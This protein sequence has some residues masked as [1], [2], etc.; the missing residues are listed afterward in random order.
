MK[1]NNLFLKI[2]QFLLVGSFIFWLGSY[3]SRHLVVYQLFEPEGLVLRS[4]YDVENLKTVWITISPLIVSNIIAFPI[5][6]VLYAIYLIVSKDSLKKEGWLFISTLIILVTAPF[7]I[8][9]LLKDYKIISLIY[10]SVIDSN[11]VLELVRER[12]TILSSFSL[13][14]IFSYLAIIFLTILKPLSK[15]DE[16][17]RE[18]T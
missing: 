6:V 2:V 18:G 12:I 3:I 17:K 7:E 5:F 15:S 9:L 14:E 4:V 16:N 11:K 10:S 13:I 8:F 1:N